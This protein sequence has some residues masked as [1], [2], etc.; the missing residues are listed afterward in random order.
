MRFEVCDRVAE[1]C[2]LSDNAGYASWDFISISLF[3]IISFKDNSFIAVST[4]AGIL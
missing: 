2:S 1:T 4:N 3:I